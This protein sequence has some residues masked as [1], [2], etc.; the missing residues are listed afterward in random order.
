MPF[1]KVERTPNS[2]L[3]YWSDNEVESV[4][5]TAHLFEIENGKVTA[6]QYLTGTRAMSTPHAIQDTDRYIFTFM[7]SLSPHEIEEDG[8][9]TVRNSIFLFVIDTNIKLINEY[10]VNRM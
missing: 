2:T 1:G 3:V 9:E 5:R 8:L 6:S 7:A 4:S 10:I